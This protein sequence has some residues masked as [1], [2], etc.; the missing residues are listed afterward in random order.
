MILPITAYGHP[1]LKKVAS[2]IDEHFP[3]L[4][5]LIENMFETMYAASGV[6]LAAPQVNQSIRLIVLDAT[7]FEKEHPELSGFKKVLINPHI[8]S[9][10]GEEWAYNEGCLSIPDIH[11]DVIRKS[12][13]Q[14]TYQD[15]QFNV[16]HETYSGILGRI[17]QHEYDHLE[18]KLFV[19]HLTPLK[20]ILLKRKLTDISSG[21]IEAKYKMIFP[22]LKKKR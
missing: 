17:I 12:T 20:K 15:E 1:T 18:G 10:E 9:L 19:D 21:Q 11:E 3:N 14:I 4:N 2:D 22:H 16:H 6:G 8:T 5:I 13:V 7:P